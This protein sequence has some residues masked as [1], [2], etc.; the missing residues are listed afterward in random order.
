MK[1]TI[2]DRKI[3]LSKKGIKELK[4]AIIQLEQDRRKALAELRDL[5]KT[6]GHDERLERIEK[7]ATLDNIETELNEKKFILANAKLIPSKRERLKVAIGSVVDLIDMR[8][9]IL[10]FTIVDSIEANPSDGRISIL[11][12]LGKSLLGR[13]VKDIIKWGTGKRTNQF[14]LVRIT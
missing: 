9:H 2:T 7:L 4:K 1:T 3:L 13:T 14:Q 8:G 10:R 6:F 5:E 12:P 11:S